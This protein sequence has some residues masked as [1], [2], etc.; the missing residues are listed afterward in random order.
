M[1]PMLRG[2]KKRWLLLIGGVALGG[3]A[4]LLFG[5]AWSGRTPAVDEAAVEQ[6]ALRAAMKQI[7]AERRAL[8][9]SP[10]QLAP[11]A[12]TTEAPEP[13]VG[14][15]EDSAV[16]TPVPPE[17]FSFVE[18]PLPMAKAPLAPDESPPATEPETN[19]LDWLGTAESLALVRRQAERAERDWSFGWLRLAR[20]VPASTVAAALRAHGGEL[21]GAA[22]HLAR[23]RLPADQERLRAVD[24]LPFVAAVGAMPTLR[25]LMSMPNDTLAAGAGEQTPVLITLM[26]DD[27]DGRWRRAL[28]DM[29]AAVGRFRADVRVYPANV[30]AAALRAIA[31]ADFV[32]AVQPVGVVRVAH[33]L[34]VP[35][36]GA[37]GLRTFSGSPGVF[38]G[39]GAGGAGASVPVGVMDTGLNI[40]HLDISSNRQSICGV[41]FQNEEDVDLWLDENG[42]GTHVTGTLLGNGYHDPQFAGVAPGVQ[43][44]RFAKVLGIEGGGTELGIWGGMDYFAAPSSCAGGASTAALMP[45]IVNMSLSADNLFHE[46]TGAEERK[47]DGLVWAHRQLYVVVHGNREIYGFSGI[48][49]AKNTLAVGAVRNDGEL[50]AFSSRG[51]TFD[52][53]LQ[54]QVVA[55]GVQVRSAKGNGSADGY[56]IQSGTSMATPAVAGV[57]ALLMDASAAHKEQPALV[58]ARL[59]ASAIKPDAW[60]EATA[61][62]PAHNSDGPGELQDQY[63]LGKVSAHTSVLNRDAADGWLSG[64]G[65]SE[66]QGGEYAWQDVVVPAGASRLDLVL[67]WDEPPA[68]PVGRTVLND[69]DLWLDAD[70]DCGSGACGEHSSRSRKDNVEWIIVRNPAPGTYRAKVAAHRLYGTAPRAALA[71]TVIRGPSTPT[72]EVRADKTILRGH[73]EHDLR[74]SVSTDSYVAAGARLV[75]SCRA[76]D[77]TTDCEAI[78]LSNLRVNRQDGV[79]I[80]E[81]NAARS[82]GI[83]DLVPVLPTVNLAEEVV[84]PLGEVVVGEVQTVDLTV[85][86]AEGGPSDAVRL[87]FTVSAWNA[88]GASLAV[89]LV[90]SGD[91]AAGNPVPPPDNDHFASAATLAD[92]SG[93]REFDL[94]RSTTGPGEVLYQTAGPTGFPGM[95]GYDIVHSLWYLWRAPSTGLYRFSGRGVPGGPAV[96]AFGGDRLADLERLAHGNSGTVAFF[97]DADQRLYIRISTVSQSAQGTLHWAQGLPENDDFANATSISGAQGSTDGDNGGAGM[98][99][100]EWFGSAAATVWFRWTAPR[101]GD[102]AFE[103]EKLHNAVMVFVGNTVSDLRLVSGH[104]GPGLDARIRARDGDVYHVA[105][106]TRDGKSTG[107]PFTL[108]WSSVDV[109]ADL[110]F[111]ATA[112][113]VPGESSAGHD[114]RIDEFPN[115]EPGEPAST[116]VRTNWWA[117]TAPAAGRFTWRLTQTGG[118][119]FRIAAWSGDAMADAQ[120]EA[121]SDERD[122]TPEF[123]LDAAAGQ[124]YRISLGFLADDGSAF[125]YTPSAGARLE[126][127]PTP[128]N[129][130]LAMAIA[131]SGARGEISGDNGYATT[132]P[133]E[134]KGRLG[135]S[136]LWWDFR[137]PSSGAYRF[138]A[139][140]PGR[141]LAVYRR[142]GDGYGGLAFLASGDGD[143]TFTAAADT[144]YA[145]RVGSR[146]AETGGF[147]L[148]WH[149]QNADGTASHTV[150][151][152]PAAANESDRE[153]P[154][155]E[156]IEGFARVFN[157]SERRGDVEIQAFD[158]AG[159]AAQDTVTVHLEARQKVH[160]NSGDLERGNAQKSFITGAVG[161]GQGDWRLRLTTDLDVDVAVYARALP[162]GFLTSLHDRAPCVT[163]RCEVVVFNPASNRNQRSLLRLVNVGD[164]DA[165]VTIDGVDDNGASPGATVRLQLPAG[166]A[167]TLTAVELETGNG[168]GLTGALGDGA[169]KW[170][171]TV[172]ADRQIHV[173]SL[174]RSP[175]GHLT[176]LSSIVR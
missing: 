14:G 154:D 143:V 124:R 61:R 119:L 2:L 147:T 115:V 28:E 25:K 83:D 144:H 88:V 19:G 5:G 108:K 114:V 3:L 40:N 75:V 77:G 104:P 159:Q 10:T 157:R 72:L 91:R 27:A 81:P 129:D 35:A 34:A 92:S 138:R 172:E 120:L 94:L 167:R 113:E 117:W 171:L 74:V 84:L 4:A 98:E 148:R 45:L 87:Y 106:A 67:T 52:G 136:S 64:S 141:V 51:P 125:D 170:E 57:A 30:D 152:F 12:P 127:A 69:L 158:D 149:A 131:I 112:E 132:E 46:G 111:F 107:L 90:G 24:T 95:R 165:A 54:P 139:D 130:G 105:V 26:T 161:D 175:S 44:I 53:R 66:P 20:D 8:S 62:F 163:N 82:D 86:Y 133:D 21:L 80:T 168:T 50:A 65:V 93:S 109:A 58:R 162:S 60:L 18:A 16:P 142:D 47:V 156:L 99:L 7:N 85:S 160:F 173:V 128:A 11:I 123:V 145:I 56:F 102:F 89:D 101:D 13:A 116:G 71:W 96:D 176:N 49:S 137:A 48:G 122:V 146:G 118:L 70:G 166:T 36:M 169:G 33:D 43:H 29:G 121:I 73:G 9:A 55:S 23:V 140:G 150:P 37:D 134:A 79:P 103:T 135:H 6:R 68:E 78:G 17:G 39:A 110:N 153:S 59:M 100:G 63:G 22:G 32:A 15:V 42:H 41:N 155:H 164:A 97:A 38:S 76:A 126:W 1:A 31:A 151:F 174:M